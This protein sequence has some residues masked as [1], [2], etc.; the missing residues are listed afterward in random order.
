M[1]FLRLLSLLIE[2][3]SL[4]CTSK[5]NL[6]CTK[7]STDRRSSLWK[8]YINSIV[9]SLWSPRDLDP[10]T[11]GEFFLKSLF[12]FLL[13]LM[14]LSKNVEIWKLKSFLKT[15]MT[16]DRGNRLPVVLSR[17]NRKSYVISLTFKIAIR[18]L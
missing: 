15:L 8:V 4:V 18:R 3:T 7:L 1:I 11:F 5:L 13:F 2:S 9:R 17:T 12:L 6:L 14:V 10:M 16:D